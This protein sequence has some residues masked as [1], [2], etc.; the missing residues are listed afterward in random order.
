MGGDPGGFEGTSEIRALGL[1]AD[2]KSDLASFL[3]A[4]DGP[5]PDASLL[6]GP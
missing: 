1:S 4:L 5:G 2:E 3:Q 6:K